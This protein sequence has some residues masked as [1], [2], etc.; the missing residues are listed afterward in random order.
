MTGAAADQEPSYWEGA[1][2]VSSYADLNKALG[3]AGRPAAGPLHGGRRRPRHPRS[4]H[5][6]LDS[7]FE[8]GIGWLIEHVDFLSEPLDAL[9]GDPDEVLAQARAWHAVSA[10][11]AATAIGYREAAATAAGGWDGAAADAYA[12][13]VDRCT[14]A[15]DGSAR[16]AEQLST[17]VATTGALVG[18]VRALI[19][20]AIASFLSNVI[21]WVIAALAAAA[22]TAGFSLAALVAA[23]V[24]QAISLA[25][26]FVR[27]ISELL[28]MLQTAG[29][30]VRQL[31]EALRDTAAGL[32]SATRHT[33]GD[34]GAALTRPG[35]DAHGPA[36]RRR[37]AGHDGPSRHAGGAGRGR[38][39]GGGREAAAGARADRGG[40]TAHRRGAG[41]AGLNP[42]GP[43]SV[44]EE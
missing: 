11:L 4:D 13:A 29:S 28:D 21:Q 22:V 43:A 20:D 6:P 18:T 7:L 24:E 31:G 39:R 12:M 30:T 33:A 26:T 25:R 44:W 23:I 27:R 10:E 36:D 17:L 40:Q 14:V 19:R 3:A 9:A 2:V 32:A 42:A 8:A 1:G 5:Q 15:M 38:C 35:R 37:G 34:M 41:A 16:D